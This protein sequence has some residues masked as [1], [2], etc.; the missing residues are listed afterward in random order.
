MHITLSLVVNY[1]ALV[2]DVWLGW[3]VVT[4]SPRKLISWLTGLSLLSVGGL[5]LN[6][7]LALSPPPPPV[8]APEWLPLLFP[9]WSRDALKSGWSV[10]LHGWQVA[11]AIVLWHHATILM[12]PGRMDWWR[13]LRVVSGYLA[14]SAAIWVF[15]QRPHLFSVPAGDPLFLNAIDPGP[16]YFPFLLLL[17][18]FTVLSLVNLFRSAHSA[19]TA[20]PRKQLVILGFATILA[21]LT[22]P[23]ALISVAL[24]FPLPQILVSFFLLVAVVLIGFGVARYSALTEGRTMRRDFYYNAIAMALV[25]LVYSLVTWVSVTM[26]GLPSAAFI[27]VI[28]L[29]IITH[30]LVDI[31]RRTLDSLFH[32]QDNRI[33]RE[34]L[35]RLASE[36]G[37]QDF[38]ENIT[39]ALKS[40]CDTIRATFGILLLFED[41]KIKTLAA[42]NMAK[43]QIE[44]DPCDFTADD[45]LE[46]T[47][48]QF[49]K[50]LEQAVLLVP[51]YVEMTQVG[52]ILFGRPVNSS[53]YSKGDIELLLYPSDQL[54]D[55]I[56]NTLR[57]AEY[58]RQLSQLTK[59]P[60]K[61]HQIPVKD[62]EDALRNLYD[63]AYLGD[64]SLAGLRLA[65]TK[66]MPGPTTHI[67]RGKAVYQVMVEAIEILKPEKD[68]PRDPP[69]REWYPYRIL[70][71]A[72][73]NEELNREIMAKLYISEGTFNRTRRSAVRS[74]ARILGE[75]EATFN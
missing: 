23:T 2:C 63:Y 14:A 1:L 68:S 56:H 17:M 6:I 49:R 60:P 30:N 28:I 19:P 10:W 35:R 52:A 45:V 22:V 26:F 31:T 24:E 59:L 51:I 34:N 44:Q 40:I 16:L 75:I 36:V 48:G 67:D 38:D 12:R 9:F 33:L 73:L 55:A 8:N 13:C 7:L 46:I 57:E 65:Q 32:H 47:P 25:V 54:A 64:S 29:A 41:Q 42:Y 66:L 39:L 71:G 61:Q 43:E 27:F 70:H 37:M 74:V 50:P 58:L 4:R 15:V 3:Y 11:P 18:L 53:Q 5:F 72:Y 20:L 62:V 21:G 69:P